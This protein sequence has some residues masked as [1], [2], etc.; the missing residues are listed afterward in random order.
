MLAAAA[1]WSQAL[2]WLSGGTRSGKAQ[3][4]VLLAVSCFD[5]ATCLPHRCFHDIMTPP[6][7][8]GEAHQWLVRG[9]KRAGFELSS[10]EFKWTCQLEGAQIT[11]T[12][13]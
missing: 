3:W 7:C 4:L 13:K 12:A 5:L 11:G 9:K 8:S 10:I 2:A 1:V 6:P